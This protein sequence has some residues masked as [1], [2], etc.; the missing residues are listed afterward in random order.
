M[1]SQMLARTLR[2]S[3]ASPAAV[4]LRPATAQRF[5]PILAHTYATKTEPKEKAASVI[6]TLPDTV[7]SKTGLIA[8]GTATAI[9]AISNELYVFGDETTILGVFAA[10]IFM[11][12]KVVAPAY[13]QWANEYIAN[14]KAV[15]NKS[16]EEHT[17][18]VKER[19]AGVE[20][21]KDVAATTKI[22]FEVSKETVEL[23]A[24]AFELKQSVEFAHEAK[25]VLDSWVR[26]EASV[27]QREQKQL[28]EAVIAKIEKEIKTPKFQKEVL[29]QSVTDIQKL[30][31]A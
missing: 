9:Y 22:L 25:S 6:A 14:L 28:A 12:A 18:A 20:Q 29:D 2:R 15:L 23:E 5:A 10:F 3:I 30:F 11:V 8:T 13:T 7:L 1:S 27:R 24:K 16:R 4:L 31:A 21:L 19:I 17:A 26:Y